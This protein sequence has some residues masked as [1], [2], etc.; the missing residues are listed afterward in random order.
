MFSAQALAMA[1]E[2][3]GAES[4]LVSSRSRFPT[5]S[6]R[7]HCPTVKSKHTVSNL[8]EVAIKPFAA[9]IASWTAKYVETQPETSIVFS[10]CIRDLVLHNLLTGQLPT[11]VVRRALGILEPPKSAVPLQL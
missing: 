5:V 4:S 1:S 10:K 6:G 3:E 9:C 11:C 8:G 2:A 7:G